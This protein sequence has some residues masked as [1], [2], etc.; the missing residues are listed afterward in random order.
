MAQPGE[1]CG[2][3]PRALAVAV[4]LL[5]VPRGL[6]QGGAC[7]EGSRPSGRSIDEATP[8]LPQVRPET[9]ERVQH[10]VPGYYL[11]M[12][13]VF[14]MFVASINLILDFSFIS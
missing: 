8:T 7:G 11:S 5:L 13:H 12:I 9:A 1:M 10:N 14:K 6:S 4:L 2:E 3:D